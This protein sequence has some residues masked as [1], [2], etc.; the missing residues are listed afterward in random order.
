MICKYTSAIAIHEIEALIAHKT[1]RLLISK[2]NVET[3]R[4][5]DTFAITQCQCYYGSLLTVVLHIYT[6]IKNV[7]NNQAL[8]S[9]D[10]K[11]DRV[12]LKNA[13]PQK[14]PKDQ[15]VTHS[16]DYILIATVSLCMLCYARNQ[17]SNIL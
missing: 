12:E 10:E 5:F 8:D 17:R 9:N 1:L 3:L 15:E 11:E 2:V 13:L 16:R 4:N 14:I 7:D 6:V